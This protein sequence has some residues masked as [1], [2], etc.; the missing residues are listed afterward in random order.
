MGGGGG[1]GF[2]V[3]RPMCPVPVALDKAT[4]HSR[5]WTDAAG[6]LLCHSVVVKPTFLGRGVTGV[7]HHGEQ[8]STDFL[9]V[10]SIIIY[11]NL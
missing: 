1:R 6:R 5:E 9:L 7:K 11:C 4:K 2:T 3:L 10:L 8:H